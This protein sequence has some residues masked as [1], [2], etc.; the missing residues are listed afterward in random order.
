MSRWWRAGVFASGL[1]MS[2][3]AVWSQYWSLDRYGLSLAFPEWLWVKLVTGWVFLLAGLVAKRR[4]PDSV[5]GGLMIVFSLLW[6]GAAALV[7]PPLGW[8]EVGE[9][10]AIYGVLLVVLLSFPAGRLQGW[11]RWAGGLWVAFVGVIAIIVEIF[12]DPYQAI[13]DPLCCPEPLLFVRDD[14]GL[15]DAVRTPA[16]VV[17]LVVFVGLVVLL[18]R[19]WR[20]STSAGR[21]TTTL[22]T[23]ALP[24]M[25]LVVAIPQLNQAFGSFF[26]APRQELYIENVALL[27]LPGVILTSLLRTRLV[28][29]RVADMM[30]HL[31]SGIT[32]E[33]LETRLQ[34]TLGSADVRLLFRSDDVEGYVGASGRPVHLSESDDALTSLGERTA[35]LH[36]PELDSEL[37]RSAGMAARLAIN[38]AR[39][40]AELRSQ[41]MFVRESRRR[42]VDATDEARRQVERDLHDGAQQ[43]LVALSATL[44]DAIGGSD[45]SP[46]LQDLLAAAAGETDEAIAELRELAHG[47]HPA[48]L[49]QAGLGPAVSSLIDRAPIPVTCDI[50]PGRYA[51]DVEATAYFFIAEALANAFKHSAADEVRIVAGIQVNELVV[52]VEDNGSGGIDPTGTGLR[53]L[54]DRVGALG[55]R[56]RVGR[57]EGEG[58]SLTAWIPLTDEADSG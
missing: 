11:E 12:N 48:I 55:G 36:D 34:E 58:A 25:V 39:L 41:L 24:L 22:G 53:G 44:K 31:D 28:H 45:V 50:T 6:I 26:F 15:R 13:D 54:Q 10:L 40:Q 3:A 27:I 14:P 38:N 19:R 37:V 8:W 17:G 49:T 47:V 32:P 46:E 43:R 33:E 20:R 30:R 57:P 9:A 35:I 4:R 51:D 18:T 52:V 7:A 29:A 2:G 23:V 16:V 42:L 56:V 21:R 1:A 5:I